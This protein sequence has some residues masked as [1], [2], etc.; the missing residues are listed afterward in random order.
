MRHGDN[1]RDRSGVA[2]ASCFCDTRV[3]ETTGKSAWAGYSHAVYSTRFPDRGPSERAQQTRANILPLWPMNR[4]EMDADGQ[5]KTGEGGIRTRGHSF[6]FFWRRRLVL[7]RGA[8][9]Y[10]A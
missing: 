5:R 6:I 2:P 3:V 4:R 10:K 1:G 8:V 7:E 9:T